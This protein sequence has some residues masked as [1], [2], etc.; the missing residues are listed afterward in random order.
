MS[1]IFEEENQYDYKLLNSGNV[2][3]SALLKDTD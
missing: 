3:T 2:A 1:S